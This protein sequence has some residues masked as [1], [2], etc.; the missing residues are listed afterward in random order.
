MVKNCQYEE[1][2][3]PYQEEPNQIKEELLSVAWHPDRVIDW[4]FDQKEKQ[5]FK[6]LSEKKLFTHVGRCTSY[7]KQR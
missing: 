1:W 4:C 3:E 2:V 7:Y 5:D 6:K